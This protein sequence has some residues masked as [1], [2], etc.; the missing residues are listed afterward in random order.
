MTPPPGRLLRR[1]LV[2]AIILVSG[3]LLTSGALDLVFRYRESVHAIE[4]LQGEMARGAA[5]KIEEFVGDIERTMRSAAQARDVI[6]GELTEAY[7]F[8]LIKLLKMS[9]AITEVAAVDRDGRERLRLSRV[10]PILPGDLA[11]R[12]RDPAFVAVTGGKTFLGPVYFVRES[13]P[14]MTVAV[15]MEPLPGEVA[16]ALIA[17]V[18]LTSVRDVVLGINV[19]KAGYAYVVSSAGDLIAHPDL[20]FVLEKRNLRNLGQVAAAVAGAPG[21]LPPQPSLTGERVLPAFAPIAGP[22]WAVV[23]ERP[24]AEAYA[25]LYGS[26]VRTSILV[27]VGLG[28]A[29]IASLLIGR[30][31]VR[32]VEALRQGAA[33]IGRGDLEYRLDVKTGDELQALAEEF[34]RMAAQLQES[35]ATLE[36]RIDERTLELAQKSRELEA[37]SRHKSEFLANMSHELRTPLNSVIGFSEVL[38][39]RMFGD[40][41]PKQTQYVEVILASGRHL[42]TLINDILDLSKIEAG[43]MELELTTFSLPLAIQNAVTLVSDRAARYGIALSTT[44]DPRVATVTADE[45]KLKQILLNLLANAVKFTGEG[46]RVDVA[47][48]LDDGEVAI[49]VTDTGIGIAE[50]DQRAIF[51]EFR[52]AGAIEGRPREGTGLG[53]PL[54]KRFAELHGGRIRVESKIGQGSTFTFT[55]PLL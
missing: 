50:E 27:L 3:G 6:A 22:S 8:E 32:P 54:A 4:T 17:D 26:I 55:I 19:G 33:R 2:I 1:T 39:D 52:Q 20:S 10:R 45:R 23:V 12:G 37:A 41:N 35:Y 36:Q 16:G 44:L 18:S 13:E 9:P 15:P 48:R 24:L 5:A 31:V 42:L 14:Y 11:D 51:E 43:R 38:R 40:L 49:S 25:P 46:G 29:V 28:M 21:V 7:R 30:R 47:A 34:N 53:L